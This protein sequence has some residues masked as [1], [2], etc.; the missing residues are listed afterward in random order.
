[1]DW[2][3]NYLSWPLLT[4][5]CAT[6]F[7]TKLCYGT[8]SLAEVED[9]NNGCHLY[10]SFCLSCAPIFCLIYHDHTESHLYS[11]WHPALASFGAL[12]CKMNWNTSL[13]SDYACELVEKPNKRKRALQKSYAKWSKVHFSIHWSSKEQNFK[14]SFWYCRYNVSGLTSS[15]IQVLQEQKTVATCSGVFI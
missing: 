4:S 5:S 7:A 9:Q 10:L 13:C 12:S 1:M 8:K 15:F 11:R 14:R 6:M 2:P 3:T